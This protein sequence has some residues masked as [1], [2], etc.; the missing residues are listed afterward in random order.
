V[1]RADYFFRGVPLT[2]GSHEVELVFD[3]P[4]VWLGRAVSLFTLAV[5]LAAAA[6]LWR[7]PRRSVG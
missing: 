2:P 3:P 7:W 4:A 1:L 5:G 6:A